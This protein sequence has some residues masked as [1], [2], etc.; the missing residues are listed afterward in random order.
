MKKQ[1]EENILLLSFSQDWKEALKEWSLVSL[2]KGEDICPCGG[3]IKNL[4]KI[5]NNLTGNPAIVGTT[6][7]DKFF[8]I[9]AT[10]LFNELQKSKENKY[11]IFSADMVSFIKRLDVINDWEEEFYLNMI[12]CKEKGWKLSAKQVELYLKLNL[13]IQIAL[14]K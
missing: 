9:P 4:V 1:F 3:P 8:S 2:T 14:F 12:K 13:R 5:V 11:Y 6:C 10:K 7:I